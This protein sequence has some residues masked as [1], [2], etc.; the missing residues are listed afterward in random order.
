[1]EE[2]GL[3]G[4]KCVWGVGLVEKAS[5]GKGKILKSI[6]LVNNEE[7]QGAVLKQ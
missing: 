5:K 3:P 1:M 7:T 2:E 6:C 4:F